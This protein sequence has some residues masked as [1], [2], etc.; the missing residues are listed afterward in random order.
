MQDDLSNILKLGKVM[1]HDR[2]SFTYPDATHF[3]ELIPQRLQSGTLL[4]KKSIFG[5]SVAVLLSVPQ[6]FVQVPPGNVAYMQ[7]LS[8]DKLGV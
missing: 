4:S 8:Q 2:T 5:I 3:T 7:M 6:D 1:M